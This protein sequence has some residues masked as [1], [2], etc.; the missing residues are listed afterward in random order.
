MR[1]K[2]TGYP[3][4]IGPYQI[5]EKIIFWADKWDDKDPWNRRAHRLGRWLAQDRLGNDSWLAKLCQW[6]H[7]H[8]QN[9]GDRRVSVRIDNTDVYSADHTLA[10]IIAP[11]LRKLRDNKNGSPWVDN[12]DL[13]PELHMSKRETKIF[14]EGSWNK[15]LKVTEAEKD[16]INKKYHAGWE[17]VLEEM[18][19]A[20][21]QHERGDW[22]DQFHTGDHDMLWQKVDVHGNALGEP[23]KLGYDRDEDDDTERDGK[24]L[25]QMVHGPNDTHVYDRDGAKAW[26]DRMANGRRLFAKYYEALWW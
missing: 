26:S 6:I 24:F 10:L 4:W 13:P 20:F 2:I 21:E 7:K 18:I 12:A 15:R 23:R 3:A 19:W 22:D 14:N 25:Y 17:W 11:T 1:V 9:R 16:A 5:A 8:L